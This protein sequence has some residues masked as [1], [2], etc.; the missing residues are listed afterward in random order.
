MIRQ[1]RCRL[2][3][4]VAVASAVTGMALL[5]QADTVV[6]SGE[7]VLDHPGETVN[8]GTIVVGDKSVEASPTLELKAGDF[9]T[10]N[11]LYL[12][13]GSGSLA[14]PQTPTLK[15]DKDAS[16]TVANMRTGNNNGNGNHY[17]SARVE[18]DGGLL[19][20]GTAR[21]NNAVNNGMG[22]HS[23]NN[24]NAVIEVKNG[25]QF[26]VDSVYYTQTGFYMGYNANALSTPRLE[27]NSGA[28]AGMHALFLREGATVD[29]DRA[30]FQLN[31]TMDQRYNT[32][33]MGDAFFNGSTLTYYSN[34]LRFDAFNFA[35]QAVEWFNGARVHVGADGLTMA[36][37]GH[38]RLEGQLLA[39]EG[40]ERTASVNVTGNG[41]L[42]ADLFG[43]TVPVDPAE[44]VTLKASRKTP[45]WADALGAVTINQQ[46]GQPFAF[47]GHGALAQGT[48]HPTT[49]GLTGRLEATA[50]NFVRDEWKL[51]DWA[52]IYDDGVLLL[53]QV[54]GYHAAAAWKREKVDVTRSF[55]LHFTLAYAN[56]ARVDNTSSGMMAVWQNSAAGLDAIG[57]NNASDNGYFNGNTA[58]EHSFGVGVRGNGYYC[59]GKDKTR[60]YGNDVAAGF[61][62]TQLGATP[63]KRLYVTV[64]YD[65]DKKEVEISSYLDATKTR[66]S[67]KQTG[68]D[69]VE[70]TGADTAYF[71]FTGV[72]NFSC[73]GQQFVSECSLVYADEET[74]SVL[75]HLGGTLAL[76][77]GMDY[78]VVVRGNAIQRGGV[79]GELAYG[80]GAKLTVAN[81]GI[82]VDL[83]D[84]IPDPSTFPSS[85][86]ADNWDYAGA[87]YGPT[88]ERPGISVAGSVTVGGVA[89]KT[90]LPILGDWNLSFDIHYTIAAG[91]GGFD[92]YYYF[93]LSHDDSTYTSFTY[94]KDLDLVF[95][96]FNVAEQ[97]ITEEKKP[98]TDWFLRFNNGNQDTVSGTLLQNVSLHR[99]EPIHMDWSY[100]AAT[101]YLTVVMKQMKDGE[102]VSDT[103]VFN[104][105]NNL[106]AANF[107]DGT[108]RFMNR[109][110]LYEVNR[111]S[112][113]FGNFAF[114]SPMVEEKARAKAAYEGKVA[115]GFDKLVPTEQGATVEKLGKGALV[116]TEP[117]SETAQVKLSEGRLVLKKTALEPLTAD[118]D[119]GGWTFSDDTGTWGAH[120]GLK[121]NSTKANNANNAVTV[122]RK[123]VS[124][125]WRASFKVNL[126]GQTTPGDAFSF[127]VQN[128]PNG[129]HRLGPSNAY[130]AWT[131][132]HGLALGWNVYPSGTNNGRLAIARNTGFNY[133][134]DGVNCVSHKDVL[135]LANAMTDVTL[136]HDAA[137]KTLKVD[138]AQ[139]ADKTFT[140]TFENVD[141]R[142]YVGGD[143]AYLGF[144]TGGGGAHVL[145]EFV[146]F[147]FEQ[148]S[149]DDPTAELTWLGGVEL[150][151]AVNGL[152]IDTPL[153]GSQVR[154]GSVKVP[155]GVTFAPT[156]ESARG[157]IA[158]D[159]LVGSG[160]VEID[161]TKADVKVSAVDEAVTSLVVKGPGKI[162]LPAGETLKGCDICLLGEASIEVLGK[163]TVHS[164]FVNDI[165]QKKG[166]YADGDAAWLEAPSGA[167]LRTVD[168][169]CGFTITIR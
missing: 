70:I 25:G 42:Q 157:V 164:V 142:S 148:L 43:T 83:S 63:D 103:A 39:A 168:P 5:G 67:A 44:T 88:V 166:V 117:G 124:G 99:N 8:L 53:G 46:A 11:D 2:V 165:K 110:S 58:M 28:T 73:D 118:Y 96:V 135:T 138:L 61:T 32:A 147:R 141:I 17:S 156:S 136:T 3:R 77:A 9:R 162:I 34:L 143:L 159:T 47:G 49:S 65:A 140:H 81:E 84:D 102:V 146:D 112:K 14:A 115:V 125:N 167:R 33:P 79:L 80:D 78:T 56:V 152:A 94:T 91:A 119:H 86:R 19:K 20:L 7:E 131:G 100:S 45:A 35:G 155:A 6:T 16:L 107:P 104:L 12:A 27:V 145:P 133:T 89:S 116:V 50:G 55:T 75:P 60:A 92:D 134:V 72:S 153:A 98:H 113:W 106:S 36:I 40:A 154:V 87:A 144:G 30:T 93:A 51:R 22:Y 122:G 101:H 120:R 1:I 132:A 108:A 21:T 10:G 15:I 150:T 123:A 163:T 23:E 161:T 90:G 85:D 24:G 121:L 26:I 139:G 62:A 151:E 126:V 109:T 4:Q 114:S 149:G 68:I 111:A 69:L 74:P 13:R 130:A 137:A 41:T 169:L 52:Q 54:G 66:T 38:A 158:I 29:V 18:I 76:D 48:L 127:F 105:G 128:D 57:G 37:P 64:T 82:E 129:P 97:D 31:R 71:G 160:A 59:F 95:H